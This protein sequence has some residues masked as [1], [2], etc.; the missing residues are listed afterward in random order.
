MLTIYLKLASLVAIV[1][2]KDKQVYGYSLRYLIYIY[3]V[4]IMVPNLE[5]WSPTCLPLQSLPTIISSQ[6]LSINL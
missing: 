3:F 4:G 5:A 6:K 2:K 1:I